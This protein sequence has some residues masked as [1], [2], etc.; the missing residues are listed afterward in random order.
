MDDD[1]LFDGEGTT[2]AG[3]GNGNGSKMMSERDPSFLSSAAGSAG[4]GAGY[5]GGYPGSAGAG[6]AGA[7]A[8]GMA[9]FGAAG[10]VAA[11]QANRSQGGYDGSDYYGSQDGNHQSPP[12]SQFSHGGQQAYG[13]MQQQPYGNYGGGGYDPNGAYYGGNA[14]PA[15]AAGL[16]AGAA[17][18][19]LGRT[20]S[21]A[22]TA[23]RNYQV[24][25]IPG[26][27]AGQM[28]GD[29]ESQLGQDGY[30]R[31]DDGYYQ[32][33]QGQQHHQGFQDRPR[34]RNRLS[35]VNNLGDVGEED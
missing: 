14:A 20:G 24:E 17:S 28:Y 19:G 33:G 27:H 30:G 7:A 15:A 10:A 25:A 29:N 13:G 31:D 8:A 12:G 2:A 16:G 34:N 5:A 35:V 22:S 32:N 23:A 3:S 21:I 4:G 26:G 9:G 6:G 11:H 1:E 18:A